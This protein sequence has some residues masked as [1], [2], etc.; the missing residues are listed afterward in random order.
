MKSITCLWCIANLTRFANVLSSMA[1]WW[2]SGCSLEQEEESIRQISS[3]RQPW[4]KTDLCV[5]SRLKL[6]FNFTAQHFSSIKTC[7]CLYIQISMIFYMSSNQI[8]S[9]FSVLCSLSCMNYKDHI[10]SSTRALKYLD[11]WLIMVF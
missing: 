11:F 5:S 10:H 6:S 2:A 8:W 7:L 1:G 3:R 9:C 4:G